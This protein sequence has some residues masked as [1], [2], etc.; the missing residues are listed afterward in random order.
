MSEGKKSFSIEIFRIALY[1][2]ITS[3][4][5]YLATISSDAK[6]DDAMDLMIDS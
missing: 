5:K 4:E 1:G 3:H 2:A 6:K